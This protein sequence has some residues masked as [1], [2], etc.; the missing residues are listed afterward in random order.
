MPFLPFLVFHH[1]A[2]HTTTLRTPKSHVK[3]WDTFCKQFILSTV[4]QPILKKE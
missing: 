3:S 4:T 1:L 2:A